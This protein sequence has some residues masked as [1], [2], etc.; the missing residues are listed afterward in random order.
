MKSMTIT[1][2]SSKGQVVVPASIRKELQ[3]STGAKL[4]IFTDGDNLLLKPV[5]APKLDTFRKLIKASQSYARQ[6]GLK[7]ADITKAIKKARQ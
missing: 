5:K 6:V 3:L 1:S 4:M 2:L 7:K